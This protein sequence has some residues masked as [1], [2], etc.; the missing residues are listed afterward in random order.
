MDIIPTYSYFILAAML[1]LALF[2]FVVGLNK[3]RQRI[4]RGKPWFGEKITVTGAAARF[5]K[6]SFVHRGLMT[7]R[8]LKRPIAGT[9]HGIMFIGA[10]LLIFGH[11][12]FAL[13]FIGLNVYEGWFGTVFLKVGR[14]LG[15]ILLFTGVAF[16]L[17]RRLNPPERLHAG[18]HSRAGFE[19]GEA[20]LLLIVI[21]G[22][23]T[24]G[25]RLAAE[26]SGS[27]SEFLGTAIGGLLLSVF[28]H[29]GAASGLQLM[30]WIHALMGCTFIALIS[31]G[32][33]VHMILG[34]TNSAFANS[35]PGIN[36]PPI[37]FDF[38]EDEEEEDEELSFGAA[39]LADLSQK[40]LLDATACLWC[41]R[42]HEVCPAAQTGKDLSPKK[43]MATC[44]E[45]MAE[46]KFD[47]DSLIDVL[48]LD[49]IFA[50]TSC[51]A[52][53]EECPV[54]NN[55]AEVVLE[56]RRHFVMDR[57]EMPETMAA[58]NRNLESREHPF[59]GTSSN[60]QDWRKNIEVPLFEPGETEYLLWIGCS[61]TYEERAQEIARA[62]VRILDAAGVSYGIFEEP[63]C[64]GDPA[65]MMGNEMQFVEMAE[66][67][68][69]EFKAQNI[70]KVITL[71][72]HCY[73]SFDRYYPELGANWVTVPHTVL[74]EQLLAQGKLT[75]AGG[76]DEKITFHDPCYLAR[77]NN[78]VDAPRAVIASVGQ[79]IEMPRSGK[80]S[81]CCGAGGGNYW[82][83]QG[84]TAR[85]SDVRMQEAFDTGADKVATSCSFCNL[86]LSASSTRH[87]EDRLVYDVAELVAEKITI[88]DG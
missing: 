51:A 84:G 55:P 68:I 5:N 76:T 25:F 31:H 34:P 27:N 53:V 75:L 85:I 41:G 78:I 15:G 60:P 12:V 18:E 52:C 30:W 9:F 83:G 62:M 8:L 44:A 33:F 45:Y 42:C 74:I 81:F 11:A 72:A 4:E 79:L 71:C 86:M 58:A 24:E 35:R 17:I 61:V 67:N 70:Q 19:H 88:I 13:D 28:D 36:L 10:L 80:G 57:S 26:V 37:N 73:N 22:F 2:S 32:P 39:K 46:D 3:H 47:D 29:E 16:F 54:S 65:K 87:S 69:E 50:C 49:A 66:A 59:V 82:G 77:H 48:G 7:S 1:L 21:A 38:D 63:R 20:F 40:N 56:F 64:T 14:E 6:S 23:L 43:V